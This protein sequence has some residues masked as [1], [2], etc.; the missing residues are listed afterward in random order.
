[1][2]AAV[3]AAVLTVAVLAAFGGGAGVARADTDLDEAVE[4]ADEVD[5]ART[6]LDEAREEAAALAERL[7]TAAARYEQARAHRLRLEAEA[8]EVADT[9]TDAEEAAD[10]A[11]AALAEAIAASYKRPGAMVGAGEAVLT[12]AS[13]RDA[14]HRAALV[15]RTVVG[16]HR[17]AQQLANQADR[18]DEVRRQ[19]QTLQA[20]VAGAA[21]DAERAA[22]ELETTTRVAREQ[23]DQAAQELAATEDQVRDRIAAERE[24]QRRRLAEQRRR[25]QRAEQ[26]AERAAR[27]GGRGRTVV[28]PEDT[29]G[30][31]AC[32]VSQPNSFIDS[33]HFPR[34]GGRVHVGVDIFADHGMPLRA[35]ADGTVRRAWHNRLGGLS[36]DL[37]DDRGDRYYY[38][39]LSATHVSTGDRV[40]AGEHIG[41]VGNSGNARH[42]PPHLHWQYHPG[43][44]DAVNPYPLAATLCR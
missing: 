23:A 10:H 20:G 26:R 27:V 5:E 34:P 42:T 38:A 7:Q 36:I 11:E 41:D 2:T 28:P 40:A 33:W 30:G 8:E 4:S 37:V 6:R 44:G 16:E 1:M 17:H 29:V 15:G 35:V 9:V 18:V 43:D 39:H 13:R 12:S 32:P 14:L 19:H 3:T 25:E 31:M 22:D 21:E 24:A